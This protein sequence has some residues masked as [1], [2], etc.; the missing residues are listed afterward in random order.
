MAANDSIVTDHSDPAGR[1]LQALSE[2]RINCNRIAA[3]L[4]GA[5]LAIKQD[6]SWDAD[7]DAIATV[8]MIQA[9]GEKLAA[10]EASLGSIGENLGGSHG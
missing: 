9:A 8:Y 6:D 3:I 1:S 7:D 4:H 2:A 10:L 5:V